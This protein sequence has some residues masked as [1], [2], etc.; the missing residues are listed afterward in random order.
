MI[1]FHSYKTPGLIV[2]IAGDIK[3]INNQAVYAK[4]TGVVKFFLTKF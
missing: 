2:D 3:S 4:K 1:Y